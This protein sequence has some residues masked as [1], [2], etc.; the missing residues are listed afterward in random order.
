VPRRPRPRRPRGLTALLIAAALPAAA[1]GG[2][3]SSSTSSASKSSTSA[4]S[5]SG[6]SAEKPLAPATVTL[7]V[8]FTGR[9]LKIMKRVVAGFERA[10]PG[11]KVKT[12]GGISDDKIVA[13]IRGGNAP[14]IAQSFSTDNTGSFCAS[15]AWTDLGPRMQAVGLKASA[16][17]PAVQSYTKFAGKQCALPMLADVYGLYYNKNMFAK[18]GSAGRRGRSPSS[19][20]TPATASRAASR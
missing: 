15:G 4:A 11:V 12:V 7:W 18:A 1:C 17:P 19:R 2:G 9:E 6:A 13:S 16:F 20:P 10:H 14:D 5:G 3:G 8:G